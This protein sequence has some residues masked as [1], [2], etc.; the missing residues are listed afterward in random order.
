MNTSKVRVIVCV[1]CWVLEL[2]FGVCG[3]GNEGTNDEG[4]AEIKVETV[5]YRKS[6]GREEEP[7]PEKVAVTHLI[8]DDNSGKVAEKL[9]SAKDAVAETTV[10]KTR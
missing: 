2:S 5:D 3:Q 6:A 8:H 4:A 1:E 10:K 7:H 9:Q